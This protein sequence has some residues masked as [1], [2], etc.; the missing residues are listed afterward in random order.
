MKPAEVKPKKNGKLKD[1]RILYVHTTLVDGF[2]GIINGGITKVS[3][4]KDYMIE[5]MLEETGSKAV[6]LLDG[7]VMIGPQGSIHYGRRAGPFT[8]GPIDDNYVNCIVGFD[9]SIPY[10][11]TKL[12]SFLLKREIK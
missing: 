7:N 12:S 9:E 5:D 10:G 1:V 2:P 3:M 6:Y 4:P 8:S 11:E